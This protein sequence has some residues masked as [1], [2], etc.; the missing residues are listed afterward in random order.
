G[1]SVHL[2]ASTLQALGSHEES[3]QDNLHLAEF[4]WQPPNMRHL[5][6]N[7]LPAGAPYAA[8]YGGKCVYD[9]ATNLVNPCDCDLGVA[10]AYIKG[11]DDE[12][13]RVVC[14]EVCSTVLD[15]PAPPEGKTIRCIGGLCMMTCQDD[16]G[17]LEGANCIDPETNLPGDTCYFPN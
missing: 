12:I 2:S 1:I 4:G 15:C 16:T 7:S 6:D 11:E 9:P 13:P 5:Q 10:V 14:A 8:P 17:C 3:P